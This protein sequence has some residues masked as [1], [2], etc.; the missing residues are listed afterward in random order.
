MVPGTQYYN[1]CHNFYQ[2]EGEGS[3]ISGFTFVRRLLE[4]ELV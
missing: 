1:R 3:D 2:R 4:V